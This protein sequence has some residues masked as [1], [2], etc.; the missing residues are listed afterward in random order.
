MDEEVEAVWVVHFFFYL[1]R[2]ETWADLLG[3]Q[4]SISLGC[5]SIES[6]LHIWNLA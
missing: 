3:V 2:N 1:Q 4:P 6:A 5:F